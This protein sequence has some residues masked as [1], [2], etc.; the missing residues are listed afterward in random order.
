MSVIAFNHDTICADRQETRNGLT[1]RG[2]KIFLVRCHDGREVVCA[3]TGNRASGESMI[4]WFKNGKKRE[5]FPRCQSTDDW[6]RLVV[7]ETT[8]CVFYFESAPD[9]VLVEDAYMSFGSGAETA[10]GA[11]AVGALPGEAVKAAIRHNAFCGFGV[12]GYTIQDD[13]FQ[14]WSIEL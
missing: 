11:M 6:A 12:D 5:E 8:G 13:R 3:V 14:P 1:N 10:M 9:A 4:E 7:M 2:K